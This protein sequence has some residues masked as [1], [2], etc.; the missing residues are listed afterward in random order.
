MYSRTSYRIF[1]MIFLVW[2]ASV[3]VS[4]APQFGWKDP[5]YLE[6]IEQQKCMVSQDLSYQVSYLKNYYLF[7][8]GLNR[9]VGSPNLFHN[10]IAI[11]H[12]NSN[13]FFFSCDISIFHILHVVLE[14]LQ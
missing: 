9:R 10:F 1:T 14:I 6:R 3:I 7:D 8:F 13:H 4:L 12:D 2:F 11:N 5:E